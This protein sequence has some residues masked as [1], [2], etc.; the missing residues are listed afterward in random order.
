MRTTVKK[1]QSNKYAVLF[2]KILL[3][4]IIL[5]WLPSLVD[6]KRRGRKRRKAKA[7]AN[8]LSKARNECETNC[9][10]FN[11]ESIIVPA[12]ESMNCIL[13]CISP[14][15]Y[16][17]LYAPSPL[18]RGEIDLIRGSQFESCVKEELRQE[19]L[20]AMQRKR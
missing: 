1:Q 3:V 20:K 9:L 5:L 14:K 19:R 15:C 11:E 12:E 6:G 13:Q 2:V 16:T 8:A 18:E 7:V 4:I 17:S 10:Q